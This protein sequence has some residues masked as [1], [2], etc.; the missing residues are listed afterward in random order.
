MS[1]DPFPMSDENEIRSLIKLLDDENEEISTTVNDKL[2]EK[3]TSALPFLQ[4]ALPAASPLL[5][6]RIAFVTEKLAASQAREK[7]AGVAGTSERDL[8]LEDGVFILARYGYPAE[9][10]RWCTELLDQFAHELDSKLDAHSDPIDIISAVATFFG[11]EK[12]F[13]GNVDDYFNPENSYINRVL[14]T[15]TG[16]PISLCVVI[17]LVGKRLNIPLFG[18]GMPGHFL[19]T[20]R[21]GDREIFL[22]PFRGGKLMSRQECRDFLEAT[23]HGFKDEYLAIVSSKQILERIIRNLILAYRQRGETAR[24][25][26]LQSFLDILNWENKIS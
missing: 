6:E 4:E 14:E 26:S 1:K 7:L 11:N 23:G 25:T 9:D 17:L 12:G 16:L 20:Y 5:R 3:G 18:V 21:F 10:F 8:D 19:L 22:D 13:R 24:V 15:K 2:L